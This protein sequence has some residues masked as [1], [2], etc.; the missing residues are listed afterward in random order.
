M[1]K[2][3]ILE[4]YLHVMPKLKDILREDIAVAIADTTTFLSYRPGDALDVK[5]NIG[6]SVPT[7]I[8]LYKTLKDGKSYSEIVSK[9]IFGISFKE[10]TYPIKD[11][12][13]NVIGGIG[14]G[15]SLDEQFKVEESADTLFS[16]LEETSASIEEINAGAEKLLNMID[17][18]A[19]ITQQTEKE[20]SESNEI[21][22]M[23]GNIASQS[24]LLGLNAAIEAARAGEQGKG[25]TVV[26]NEMRKLAKSSSKSSKKI[27]EILLEMNKNIKNI[28]NI[29][30][31]VQSVSES[32]SAATEEITATLEQITQSAQTMSDIA[33]VK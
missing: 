27:S 28:F 32:Q 7:D 3:G 19:E 25:F 29:V 31:Q 4:A 14:I 9:E 2:K 21:I 10:I 15:K 8:M 6:S 23:I 11:F 17:N 33:K 18:L 13:G 1:L 30:N 16:S 22:S 12:N 20:I 24:N 26:A 5:I